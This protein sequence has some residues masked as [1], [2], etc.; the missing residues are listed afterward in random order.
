MGQVSGA[1]ERLEGYTADTAPTLQRAREALDDY[2]T[3]IHA[4]DTAPNDLG[5]RLGDRAGQAVD[6]IDQLEVLDRIPAAFAA[7]LREIDHSYQ[8]GGVLH[9]DDGHGINRRILA[10][11]VQPGATP[12]QADR[13]AAAFDRYDGTLDSLA[14]HL[15]PGLARDAHAV[16][17][18]LNRHDGWRGSLAQ[19]ARVTGNT[20]LALSESRRLSHLRTR[21]PATSRVVT[22]ATHAATTAT[23]TLRTNRPF[24]PHLGA[25]LP[26]HLA[27]AAQVAARGTKL[28]GS[29]GLVAS[30]AD[31][32]YDLGNRDAGGVLSNLAS[33]GG[34][35]ILLAGVGGPV[36]MTAAAVLVVG[37]LIYEANKQDIDQAVIDALGGSADEETR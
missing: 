7:A 22:Q 23:D 29:I 3:A 12:E 21:Y 24:L 30:G 32:V 5:T 8:P 2:R 31:L 33:V 34:S 28:L 20:W 14:E 6:T 27:P 17:Q 19:F 13:T 10:H 4:Y 37:S 18:Q 11:L 36:A 9:A 16:F 15:P 1:P 26:P 25:H 35:G